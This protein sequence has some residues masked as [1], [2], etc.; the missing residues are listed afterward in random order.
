MSSFRPTPHPILRVPTPARAMEMGA[1]ECHQ[2]LMARERIIRE[3]RADPFG[4]GWEPPI[5]KVCDALLGFDWVPLELAEKIRHAL[6][7]KKAQDVLLINGGNRGGKTHYAARTAMR[8]L[9]RK[10]AANCWCCHSTQSMSIKYHHALMYTLLS[11]ELRAADQRTKTTYIA[12]KQKTGFS[13]GRFVLPPREPGAAGSECEFLSYD[14]N[15]ERIEGGNLDFIW[16]DELVPPDWVETQEFR[17]AER[18][19]KIVITF[20]PIKG[21][22]ATVK[23]FQ[24]GAAVARESIGYV[25]P[26]DGGPPDV[27]RALG[28]SEDEL[29]ELYAADQPIEV[30]GKRTVRA[31]WAPQSV[32]ENCLEW[33]V[34]S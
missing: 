17:I 27:A 29:A 23:L 2:A 22:S 8:I 9:R 16:D 5:W 21:Y 19:G 6:G 7:F 4:K 32:P 1:A 12:Y 33:Q 20:T 34:N 25:L 14:M 11:P 31:S 3:E 24:D 15:P 18:G 13:D 28:L 26:K 10:T 30:N